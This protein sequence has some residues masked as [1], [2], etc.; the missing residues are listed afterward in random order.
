MNKVE[1]ATKTLFILLGLFR[2]STGKTPVNIFDTLTSKLSN[3][4]PW[5]DPRNFLR[6]GYMKVEHD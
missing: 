2:M 4:D 3:T 6:L 1:F 5:M